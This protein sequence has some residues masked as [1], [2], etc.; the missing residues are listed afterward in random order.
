MELMEKFLFKIA[1]KWIAG[2][3]IDDALSSARDAYQMRR[4]VIINKLGEYHTTKKQIQES[5]EENCRFRGKQ[6]FSG[7]DRR[8]LSVFHASCLPSH[9]PFFLTLLRP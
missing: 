3:T 4:H 2:D 1:K 5:I 7:G 8:V 6:P 9:L